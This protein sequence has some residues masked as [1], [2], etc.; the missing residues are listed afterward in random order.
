MLTSNT[1]K[2]VC[3]LAKTADPNIDTFFAGLNPNHC[4]SIKSDYFLCDR[5]FPK[6][7]N[8]ESSAD[9]FL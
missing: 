9:Q 5:Q 3:E 8:K 7:I 2:R 4:F 6:Y 1:S